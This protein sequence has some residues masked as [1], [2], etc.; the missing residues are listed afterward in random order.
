MLEVSS[1]DSP[2][3]K[4]DQHKRETLMEGYGDGM[5]GRRTWR[6]LMWSLNTSMD[7]SG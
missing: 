7:H 5:R 1:K 4:L 2:L 6:R 3:G